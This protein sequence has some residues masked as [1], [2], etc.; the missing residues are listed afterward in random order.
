MEKIFFKPGDVVT[1]RQTLPDK[2]MMIVKS[3][4][5][6]T[7]RNKKDD[8]DARPTLFGVTC[9]WYTTEYELQEYRYNTKDLVHV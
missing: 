1:I 8:N 7:I 2:P 5:K 3:I 9:F 6:L 4:D